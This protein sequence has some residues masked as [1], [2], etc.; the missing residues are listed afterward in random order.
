MSLPQFRAELLLKGL[1]QARH[2]IVYLLVFE[3]V[4]GVL[5]DER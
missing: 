1:L 3:R 4:V 5:Q 2:E